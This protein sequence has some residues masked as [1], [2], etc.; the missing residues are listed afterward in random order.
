MCT[1]INSWF[2]YHLFIFIDEICFRHTMRN[3]KPNMQYVPEVPE[4]PKPYDQDLERIISL[5]NELKL[6]NKKLENQAII[7]QLENQIINTRS[8]LKKPDKSL[9][10]KLKNLVLGDDLE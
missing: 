9:L 1:D 2:I 5:Q 7:K 3:I 6:M 4:V 8:Q 10:T